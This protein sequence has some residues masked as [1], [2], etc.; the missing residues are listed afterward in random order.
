M[1]H[2]ILVCY[3]TSRPVQTD[4]QTDIQIDNNTHIYLFVVTSR[5]VL[6]DNPGIQTKKLAAERT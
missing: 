6:T 4:N 1:I 3:V 5:S 2:S